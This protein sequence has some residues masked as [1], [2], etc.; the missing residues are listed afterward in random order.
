MRRTAGDWIADLSLFLLAACFAVLSAETV[1]LGEHLS[2]AVLLADQIAGALACAALLLRRRWPVQLAVVLLVAG[3]F[4]HFITGPAIV[5]VFTVAA[6]RPLRTTAWIAALCFVP[7]PAFLAGGPDLD[8]P[9]TGSAITYF[10]LMAGTIGWGLFLRSRRQLVESLRE[11]A[12]RARTEARR[13]AREDIAREMHDVL[14][15]RLSLLSVHAGALAFN[16]AASAEETRRAA[17]VIRD[18]AHE[19]LE[20]LREIIGVLRAST[21]EGSRPQPVLT[22]LV[23]LVEE[24]RAAGMRVQLDM[25]VAVEDGEPGEGER[26]G[27]E[28]G[29][30]AVAPAAVGRTAYRIVQEGL[31]NARK[32]APGSPVTVTVTGGPGDGLTVRLRNP[33][34]A[35]R[36]QAEPVEAETDEPAREFAHGDE[37]P[38][39]PVPD[40]PGA[41]QGLV[42][43]A[44]RT[45]ITGGQLEHALSGGEF[46]LRAWI[47]WGARRGPLVALVPAPGS[48]PT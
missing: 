27:G 30:A 29:G 6:R 44:E 28:R 26:G 39:R 37:G 10:V 22:D 12:D 5:A 23:P 20:D 21:G 9:A 47:P 25:D 13:Q 8:D 42:G 2:P 46:E 24:S 40:V 1:L 31:T 4:S 43:L 18:T 3:V 34:E 15:H 48:D 35:E 17:G 36:D 32:H 14:A 45:R 19:A 38:A 16:P 11:R 41:G 33:V 7:V